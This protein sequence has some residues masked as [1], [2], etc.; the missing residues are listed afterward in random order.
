MILSLIID[1]SKT[2]QNQVYEYLHNKIVS[3]EILPGERMVEERIS[4]ETGISRSPIR[5]A[6]RRLGSDGLVSVSPR[7]GVKVYRPSFS[8]F[9]F[10][11]ECRLSLESSAA[12]YAAIRINQGQKKQ[13]SNLMNEMQQAINHQEMDHLR[14]LSTNFHNLIVEISGNPYLDKM[15]NQLI[16]H[17]TFYRNAV[18]KIQTRIDEGAD[19][20]QTIGEAIIAQDAK[21]AEEMMRTH[22]ERDYQFYISTYSNKNPL[23]SGSLDLIP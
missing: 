10:L 13:L 1:Q 16:A 5:E 8:D 7:G 12:H 20:H 17:L 9:K 14:S 15:M 4:K 2:L 3:G 22:I 23:S 11:Y 21:T 18:F 19:E 6:I